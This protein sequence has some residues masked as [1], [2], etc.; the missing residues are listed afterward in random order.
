MLLL[1][2]FIIR[3][4]LQKSTHNTEAK[5]YVYFLILC[6]FDSVSL[7]SGVCAIAS[8]FATGHKEREEVLRGIGIG[9]VYAVTET[10]RRVF[11]F[12][13]WHCCLVVWSEGKCEIMG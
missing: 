10:K 1:F 2:F 9:C 13:V 12:A 4:H 8:M 11:S 5:T 3:F 6:V 7:Y